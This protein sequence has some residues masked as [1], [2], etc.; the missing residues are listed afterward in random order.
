M[1]RVKWKFI[2]MKGCSLEIGMNEIGATEIEY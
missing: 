1:L 2:G